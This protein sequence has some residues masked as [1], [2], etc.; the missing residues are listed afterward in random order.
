MKPKYYPKLRYSEDEI[1]KIIQKKTTEFEIR[2]LYTKSKDKLEYYLSEFNK[3]NNF[4]SL[5]NAQLNDSVSADDR[6]MKSS[7]YNIYLKNPLLA[8]ILDTLKAGTV[9]APIHTD[10]GWYIV[11]IDNIFNNLITTETEQNKLRSEAIEAL[12]VSK[13][14][15]LSDNYVKELFDKE[16][17]V[18]KRD[19]FNFLRSYLGKFILPHEKYAG[20]ELDRKLDSALAEL[21][22]QR[23][24]KYPG[25]TLVAGA[26]YN[27]L[28]DDFIHWYDSRKEYIKFATED[29]SSFSRSLESFIWVMVRDK[30]LANVSFEKGYDKDKWVKKQC[31]WWED[32]I[33]YSSYKNE[34][35]K[36]VS[37]KV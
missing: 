31:N 22:L 26:G 19:A 4:D 16:Q 18:I 32:K 10:D 33:A 25:I 37:L 17:P 34:L 15:A 3:Q 2:W 29:L 6:K 27:Y 20:W 28:M 12:K 8:Q 30:M 14:G 11:K 35:R 13:M 7:L 36:S 1:Q 9:S 23:G 5:F 24:D 21:G